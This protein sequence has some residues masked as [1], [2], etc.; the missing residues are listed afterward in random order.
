MKNTFSSVF[1]PIGRAKF[2]EQL[3][4]NPP[5]KATANLSEFKGEKSKHCIPLKLSS[6]FSSN[7]NLI[8][9]I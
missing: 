5:Y 3:T 2:T 8:S 4:N 9:K 1:L 7:T 6:T